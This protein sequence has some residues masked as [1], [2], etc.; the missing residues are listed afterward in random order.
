MCGECLPR[1]IL[2]APPRSVSGRRQDWLWHPLQ[3]PSTYMER[4]PMIVGPFRHPTCQSRFSK[5]PHGNAQAVSAVLRSTTDPS[6]LTRP[7]FRGV[8][9]EVQDSRFERRGSKYRGSRLQVRGPHCETRLRVACVVIALSNHRA[10]YPF[11]S[12]ARHLR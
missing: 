1:P 12:G 7:T 5:G 4:R 8:R 10:G 11:W 3:A 9:F 2:F 6:E